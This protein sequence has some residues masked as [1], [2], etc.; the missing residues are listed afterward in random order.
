[1]A[2]RAHPKNDEIEGGEFVFSRA[3]SEKR[4]QRSFPRGRSLRGCA[5]FDG[6]VVEVFRGNR[7]VVGQLAARQPVI[8]LRVAGRNAAFVAPEKR[9][10]RKSCG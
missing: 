8:A 10:F 3:A 5:G 4:M 9:V 1:M 7:D 2:I 6:S